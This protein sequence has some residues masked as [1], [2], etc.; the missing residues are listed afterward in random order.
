MSAKKL[1]LVIGATGVQGM[2][3]VSALLAPQ[4]DGTPSPYSVRALTRNPQSEQAQALAA[5]GAELFEGQYDNSRDVA[6][7]LEG[8]YGAFVNTDT[9]TSGEDGEIYA[10]IKIFEQAHRAPQLRHYV[11]SG[12][13]YGTKLGNYVPKYKAIHLDGKGTVTEFLKIQPSSPSGDSLTWSIVTTGP[14]LENLHGTL[15]GPL[16]ER[17]NGAVVFGI[18]VGDGHIPANSVEDIGWWARYT[19]DHRSETSG[20]ELKVATEWMTLDELTETFTRVTGIP[21]VRKR[22]TV[23]EYLKF[24]PDL[25]KMPAVRGKQDAQTIG[26]VFRGMWSCWG[27]DLFVR[28]M[29]WIRKTHPTGYTLESWI[30]KKNYQGEVNPLWMI[31]ADRSSA[32]I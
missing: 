32:N 29:E 19:F 3:V 31:H 27:D 11:W 30:R 12:L 28:D 24:Y 10:G 15:L 18:P 14:Y 23:E 16:P 7:A 5:M 8:C 21:V 2:P 1:I 22:Y 20:K 6:L 4:D 9:F 25:Y 17:E 13:D 26:D